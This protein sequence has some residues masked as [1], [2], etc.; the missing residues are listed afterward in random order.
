M[1]RPAQVLI[2]LPVFNG[3]KYVAAAIES[4]LN[5]TLADLRL[6]ISDNASTDATEEVCRKY[7]QADSRVH[8]FRQARN[9]GLVPNF[10]FVYQPAGEPYFKW[11]GHDDILQSTYLERCVDLLER[12]SSLAL[13]QSLA[14]EVDTTGA[15]T[16]T[17]YDDIRLSGARPRDRI[18]RLLWAKHLTEQWAVLRTQLVDKIRPLGSY[19]GSDRNFNAELLILGDMGYV[20]EPL[21]HLRAHPDS[22]G[23]GAVLGKRSRFLWHDSSAQVPRLPSGLINLREYFRSVLTLPLPRRERIACLRVVAEW[24]LRRGF[25]QLTGRAD[26]YRDKI[27]R[28]YPLRRQT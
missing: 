13:A 4:I 12:D 23:S 11:T 16:R 18:W 5:Q 14:L 19:P 27:V 1:T 9:L 2:G 21:L 25:E 22:Y 17:F 10:N 20:E 28:E 24:G 8:Y 3:E 26:S 7:A 6:V 15:K